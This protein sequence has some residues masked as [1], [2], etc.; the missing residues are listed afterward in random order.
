V[1]I[2]TVIQNRALQLALAIAVLC[3]VLQLLG[4]E[5]LLRFDRAKIDGGAWWLLLTGNFVHLGTSHLLLNLAGLILIVA[6]VWPNF[7]A[8]EW[9]L[10]T[11]I[12]SI[13]VG[14]GLYWRDPGINW[15][16][17]FSG[18]L[19]GLI[20]AGTLA[21]FRRF[22]IPALLLLV[23]VCAK[24]GY[25]QLNGPVPGSES[26]AGGAV[27][28]NSHLCGAITGA[29]LGALLLGWGLY[30]NRQSGSATVNNEHDRTDS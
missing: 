23:M 22:P 2:Q 11:L 1:R 24:L 17:G 3:I 19:H 5:T 8:S 26:A 25:E 9:F 7:N 4:L 28:V 6:L 18:T 12:S 14:V 16:V 27:V 15:Y 29:V 30:R 13:G 21:D 10:I 20:M